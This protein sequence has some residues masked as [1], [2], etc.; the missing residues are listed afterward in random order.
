MAEIKVEKRKPAW[1][2]ILA[3]IVLIGLIVLF[4]SGGND[5]NRNRQDSNRESAVVTPDRSDDQRPTDS[6]GENQYGD[7]VTDNNALTGD[8]DQN[9]RDERSG[10]TLNRP[11]NDNRNNS[12]GQSDSR[13]SNSGQQNDE[14][15]KVAQFVEYVNSDF[16]EED[17]DHGNVT[18]AFSELKDACQEIAQEF[19][20]PEDNLNRIESQIDKIDKEDFETGT[21]GDIRN[22]AGVI[23][24]ELHK[25]QMAKFP[26]LKDEASKL[27]NS[28]LAIKANQPVMDQRE[29]I[30]SFL[31]EAAELLQKMD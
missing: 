28:T 11:Q 24:D 14:N 29:E 13:A 5:D 30:S 10:T 8:G 15:R 27:R 25:M 6:R 1:P 20:Y 9:D 17:F 4:I 22:T 7:D 19:D 2:W 3:G 23:A 31:S 16:K 26:Q 18:K 21:A 12:E